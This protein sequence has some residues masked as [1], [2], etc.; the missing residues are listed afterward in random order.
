MHACIIFVP[1]YYHIGVAY[2][3]IY[4]VLGPHNTYLD[5]I[6]LAVVLNYLCILIL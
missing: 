2:I 4:Q 5:V 1:V 3:Y 6:V